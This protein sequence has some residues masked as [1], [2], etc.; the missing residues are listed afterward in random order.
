MAAS[1]ATTGKSSAGKKAGTT[2]KRS[3]T[4]KAST[5]KTDKLK[6]NSTPKTDETTF[7]KTPIYIL[8]ILG[9]LTLSLFLINALYSGRDKPVKADLSPLKNQSARTVPSEKNPSVQEKTVAPKSLETP[10]DGKK[11]VATTA[12]VMV[13][14]DV[15]LYFLRVNES[16]GKTRLIPVSRRLKSPSLLKDALNEL[17]KGPSR[18]ERDRGLLSAIPKN[19]KIRDIKTVNSNVVIDFNT[20]IEENAAGTILLSRIDQIVYTATQFDNISGV[21]I[22]I[23]GK[24]RNF[25]GNDG[26]SISGPL[27][28]KGR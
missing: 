7:N 16:T 20:A 12:S 19:L 4:K 24:N 9:L 2:K 1:K 15:K 21:I 25:L 13:E 27:H 3:T 17:V 22:R 18:I 26:L 11:A 6:Q 23:N 14:K 10:I 8:T 28:R 5:A